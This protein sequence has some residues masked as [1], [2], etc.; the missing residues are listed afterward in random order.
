M[1]SAKGVPPKG[2]SARARGKITFTTPEKKQKV[3]QEELTEVSTISLILR[4]DF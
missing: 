1:T 2:K 4:A 3:V